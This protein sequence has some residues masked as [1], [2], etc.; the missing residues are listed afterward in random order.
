MSRISNLTQRVTRYG[1]L[2]T[3]NFSKIERGCTLVGGIIG[4]CAGTYFACKVFEEGYQNKSNDMYI[5]PLIVPACA[6]VGGFIGMLSPSIGPPF[7][8]GLLL[9]GPC[10]LV[11][12]Y[13]IDNSETTKMQ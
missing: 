4:T 6:Y 10:M 12:K 9:A 8:F 13:K 11:K 1:K 2:Y 5:A 7:L 3:E